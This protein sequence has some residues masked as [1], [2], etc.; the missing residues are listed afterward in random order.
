MFCGSTHFAL[1]VVINPWASLDMN[2]TKNSTVLYFDSLGG[3]VPL[4]TSMHFA[5]IIVEWDAIRQG[6]GINEPVDVA[7]IESVNSRIKFQSVKVSQHRMYSFS[8][9]W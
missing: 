9:Q 2:G 3:R 1:A 7:L 4:A 6:K 5:K 8:C